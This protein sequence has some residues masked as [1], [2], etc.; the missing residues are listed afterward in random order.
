MYHGI[1]LAK[2]VFQRGSWETSHIRISL[3]H[4]VRLIGELYYNG[5]ECKVFQFSGDNHFAA[6]L[7]TL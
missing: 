6:A 7:S 2:G 3:K 5:D 1:N 4:L